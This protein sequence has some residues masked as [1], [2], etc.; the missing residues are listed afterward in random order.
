MNMSI[1][2]EKTPN[3]FRI[4]VFRWNFFRLIPVTRFKWNSFGI[5]WYNRFYMDTRLTLGARLSTG[6][7][8]SSPDVAEWTIKN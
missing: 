5:H 7:F 6:I 2:P 3:K 1:A 4:R 8:N